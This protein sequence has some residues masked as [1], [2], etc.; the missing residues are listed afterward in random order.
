MASGA[1]ADL[2][3]LR[4]GRSATSA[5]AP[6]T[7]QGEAYCRAA[8]VPSSR[9]RV[10]AFSRFSRS[11]AANHATRTADSGSV[12]CSTQGNESP[13]KPGAILGEIQG[14]LVGPRGQS[15][16][17]VSRRV[18]RRRRVSDDREVQSRTPWEV[19][20]QGKSV[21]RQ[22]GWPGTEG[23]STG[24]RRNS[25]Q[26]AP[27]EVRLARGV[28]IGLDGGPDE[29]PPASDPASPSRQEETGRTSSS[30]YPAQKSDEPAPNWNPGHPPSGSSYRTE[31]GVPRENA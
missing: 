31:R 26:A 19:V 7:R 14:E 23:N 1:L 5:R 10:R 2:D 16:S 12:S 9:Q 8:T 24:I 27:W 4:C 3:E 21:A 18:C 29:E 25:F 17:R 6:F 13:R 11:V 30:V 15:L 22:C 28:Q 20:L